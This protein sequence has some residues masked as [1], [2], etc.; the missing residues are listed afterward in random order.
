M[1]YQVVYPVG[2]KKAHLRVKPHGVRTICEAWAVTSADDVADSPQWQPDAVLKAKFACL[3]CWR[4]AGM[5]R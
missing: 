1:M 2:A 3:T 5:T 4:G